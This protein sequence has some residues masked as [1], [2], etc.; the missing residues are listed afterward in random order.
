M[1]RT[2][3]AL[4]FSL[5]MATTYPSLAN[6]FGNADFPADVEKDDARSYHDPW[7]RQLMKTCRVR[8]QG[9]KMWVEGFKGID[10]SQLISFR[11]RRDGG[12]YGKDVH[13]EKYYYVKYY[14]NAG[15]RTNALF[16]FSNNTAAQEFGNALIR[17]YE[18]DPRP[19]PNYRLPAS[20]GPQDTHGRD[21]GLNPYD[22]PPITDW[23]QK[24]T[25]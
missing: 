25:N 11:F 16:I 21:K 4:L 6:D 8:F 2:L 20:Q 23:S 19:I 12:N 1:S 17:W 24:T 13:G 14:D 3:L 5:G 9:R 7:C 10:R 18:Q 22:K 15:I